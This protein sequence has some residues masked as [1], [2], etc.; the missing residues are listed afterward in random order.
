MD[1]RKLQMEDPSIGFVLHAKETGERPNPDVIKGQSLTTRRLT[2]LWPRLVLVNGVLW[3]RYED[4]ETKQ[5]WRQLVVPQPVCEEVMQEL[6]AGVMGGHV[7]ESKTLQQFKHGFYWPGHSL[8]IK[9]WCQTCAT[10]ASRKTTAPKICAPLQTIQAGTPM[11]A[12]AV[13]IMGPLPESSNKNSHILIV[14]D[15]F[16]RWMEAYAIHDQ[17]ATTFAQKL[18]DNVFCSLGIPEQSHSDQGKQFESKLIQ[19]LCNI[20][21]ISKT[22]STAYHPQCDGLVE[23]FN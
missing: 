1:I 5:E 7:G 20:L 2:Q 15:Y 13:D 3:R 21:S 9:K 14:A 6:H 18:V 11:Q 10:C 17:E 4:L 16:T 22:R 8:D 23:R 19:E 12:I